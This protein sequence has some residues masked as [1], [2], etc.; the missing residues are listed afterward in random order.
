[1]FESVR[2]LDY[3]GIDVGEDNPLSSETIYFDLAA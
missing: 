1:M 2:S 3:E